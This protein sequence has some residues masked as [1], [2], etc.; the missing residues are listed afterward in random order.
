M[1]NHSRIAQNE[2]GGDELQNPFLLDVYCSNGRTALMVACANG[3]I[4]IIKFAKNL[5]C[6]IFFI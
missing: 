2:D 1:S 3:N 5:T 4:E 6:R